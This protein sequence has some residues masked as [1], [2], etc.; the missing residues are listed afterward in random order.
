MLGTQISISNAQPNIFDNFIQI[1][2][3]KT[4]HERDV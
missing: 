1:D 3:L 2:A 4:I